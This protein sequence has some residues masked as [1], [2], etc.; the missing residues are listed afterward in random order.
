[1]TKEKK[2]LNQGQGIA[3]GLALGLCFGAAMDNIP[4]GLCIGVAL[5]AAYD[6]NSKKK[7]NKEDKE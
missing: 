1:M 2:P 4:L 5:G 3:I 7:E 6:A